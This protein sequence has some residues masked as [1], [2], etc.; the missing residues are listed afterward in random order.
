MMVQFS[1]RLE[2]RCRIGQILVATTNDND[3]APL[4][5]LSEED[6]A[7]TV[8]Y[9]CFVASASA[10]LVSHTGLLWGKD[11]MTLLGANSCLGGAS[12]A[13]L[14]GIVVGGCAAEGTSA[15]I[16]GTGGDTSAEGP[17]VTN[18]DCPVGQQRCGDVCV[19]VTS[20]SSNCGQCGVSCPSGQSCVDGTSRS[21]P[22]RARPTGSGG[23]S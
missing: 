10:H 6:G 20:S 16:P 12:L 8:C 7:A 13:V 23:H 1:T 11:H 4:T 9:S 17:D 22:L 21:T 14:F 5:R 2:A 15:V 19:D 3:A 18:A